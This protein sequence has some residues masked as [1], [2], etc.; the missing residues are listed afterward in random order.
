[1][2]DRSQVSYVYMLECRGGRIY[3]GYT[4]D[5]LRRYQMHL[6]GQAS[7]F[8]R[9]FPPKRMLVAWSIEAG[10]SLAQRVEYAV[11]SLPR[12]KKLDLV[13]SPHHLESICDIEALPGLIV[14]KVT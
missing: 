13:V 5:I 10:Q 14:L 8:T 4:K 11:K 1:M 2:V 3:T 12:Q 6:A 9:S 7:R